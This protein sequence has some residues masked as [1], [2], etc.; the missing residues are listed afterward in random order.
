[1]YLLIRIKNNT[2]WLRPLSEGPQL[3]LYRTRRLLFWI[4]LVM[5]KTI[6]RD[7]WMKIK[8]DQLPN[9]QSW[10][11]EQTWRL[12]VW[13]VKPANILDGDGLR[14]KRWDSGITGETKHAWTIFNQ[15][16]T[17]KDIVIHKWTWEVW[18]LYGLLNSGW[19]NL[20]NCYPWIEDKKYPTT[21]G[22]DIGEGNCQG[23]EGGGK[24]DGWDSDGGE[25]GDVVV[26]WLGGE[27]HPEGGGGTPEGAPG[28]D[29]T[30]SSLPASHSWTSLL[31]TTG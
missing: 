31:S 18:W 28:V 5:D 15:P 9:V 8:A 3:G 24:S 1:M 12:I 2:F 14:P 22:D 25:V 20:S 29:S 30:P 10:E 4:I 19:L 26:G 23:G 11:N 21:K 6:F 7:L 16:S 13:L 17:V 27:G